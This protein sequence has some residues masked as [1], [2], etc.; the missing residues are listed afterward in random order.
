MNK[1][2]NDNDDEIIE[3]QAKSAKSNTIH[4]LADQERT[5]FKKGL[6]SDHKSK[7]KDSETIDK[8]LYLARE[9]HPPKHLVKYEGDSMSNCR[10]CTWND[11]QR[12]WK[13]TGGIV[14][15]C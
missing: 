13:G 12:L 7:I 8:Y 9:R 10:L 15:H 14:K 3:I 4:R 2:I 6:L 1:S 11:R 5:I